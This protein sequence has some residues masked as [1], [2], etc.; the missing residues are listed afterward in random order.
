MKAVAFLH[1]IELEQKYFAVEVAKISFQYLENY[2]LNGVTN[3]FF[4]IP[5][6]TEIQDLLQFSN[7]SRIFQHEN[8]AKRESLHSGGAYFESRPGTPNI[9]RILLNILSSSNYVN[10]TIYLTLSHGH[11]SDHSTLYSLS[12]RQHTVGCSIN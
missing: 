7:E 10:A 4:N 6:A 8:R 5:L 11:F 2:I 3:F 1:K 9:L 12:Y